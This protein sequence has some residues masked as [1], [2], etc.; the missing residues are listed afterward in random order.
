MG[1][2]YFSGTPMN[3]YN[4]TVTEHSYLSSNIYYITSV[5]RSYSARG[6]TTSIAFRLND[7]I[8]TSNYAEHRKKPYTTCYTTRDKDKKKDSK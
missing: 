8:P 5:R 2:G 3:I 4:K 6:Y 7:L 1:A